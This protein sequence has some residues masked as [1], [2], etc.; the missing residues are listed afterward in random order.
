MN[1]VKVGI[2]GLGSWGECHLQ[3]YQSLPHVE[4]AAICDINAERVRTIAAQY[5]IADYYT[6]ED[7][8][9]GR[10]DIELVSVVTFEKEHLKS[11]VK[12]LEGGKHVLVEKPVTTDLRE[13]V[14]MRETAERTGRWLIPGHLLRFEPKS[15]EVYEAIRDGRIGRPVSMYLRRS[16]QQ[17]LFA[18]YQRTHTVYEL[19]I[20]DLD[21]AI[22][23]AGS[24]VRNVRAYGRSVSG[25][26]VPEILWANLEFANGTL[27]VLQSNW[28][29]PD[30]A[31]IEIHD[32]AEIIGVN[33]MARFETEP[34]GVQILNRQGRRTTD[35]SVHNRL[36]GRI[37]G[38]LREQLNFITQCLM[39][40]Q[41]PVHTSFADAVH[42]VQV[43]D[44]IIKS[45]KL[46]R[47]IRIE[48]LD[49]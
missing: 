27:A 40:R 5:G 24:R 35:L 39:H 34:A 17:S 22:W 16:R 15:I 37:A 30:E 48:D 13:A 43:A 44:A 12:A 20:H 25:A 47:D 46:N 18:T 1:K 10:A 42:G 26:D 23:Y 32:A 38:A 7:D 36:G 4:V 8:L 2:L 21:L 19:M 14:A 41:E 28:M 49:V 11:T 6:N 45:A 3:A 29:T 9:I 31:G 33:G